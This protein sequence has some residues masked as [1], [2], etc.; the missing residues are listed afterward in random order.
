MNELL[1]WMSARRSGT[2]QSFRAKA[3]QLGVLRAGGAAWRTAQWNL[4][5]LAH[6]EFAPAAGGDAWRVAPPVLAAGQAR[7]DGSVRAVLCGARTPGLV[8]RLRGGGSEAELA[9]RGQPEGPDLIEVVARGVGALEQLAASAGVRVQPSAPLAI[10]CCATPPKRV[11]LQSASIPL[12]GW[13]VSAFSKTA[14]EW[15]PTTPR[16]ARDARSGLF[17]F[18]SDYET[19]HIL[20]KDGAAWT[21]DP[22]AAKYRILRP[23]NRVLAY[24]ATERVLSLRATCRPP[25]LIERALVL[26]SGLIP[27]YTDGAL[28]YREVDRA[29]AQAAASVL[30]Q[31]LDS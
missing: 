20:V 3:A 31:R 26:C 8:D 22:A 27:E 9:I 25:A 15:R 13:T 28:V 11:R 10:L 29:V 7:P 14:L 12:G 24:S 18:R 16:A 1:L 2:A 17:R 6:A 30:G 23:R 21:C 5:K 4:E 19:V